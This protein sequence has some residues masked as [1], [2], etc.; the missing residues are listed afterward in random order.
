MST[1]RGVNPSASRLRAWARASSSSGPAPSK[2]SARGS[3]ISRASSPMNA[4]M[5]PTRSSGP[6]SPSRGTVPETIPSWTASTASSQAFSRSVADR[7]WSP[8]RSSMSAP[9]IAFP[10]DA[11]WADL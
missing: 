4:G 5:S 6:S 2:R 9:A 10:I 7:V 3:A 11:G 8:G 1:S